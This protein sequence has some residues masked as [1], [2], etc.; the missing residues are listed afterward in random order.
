ML[1]KLNMTFPAGASETEQI[2][3]R[4]IHIVAGITWVGLLYFFNLVSM[5]VMKQLDPSTR[6]KVMPPLMLKALWYFRWAAVVT[7]LAGFRYFMILA[8]TDADAAGNPSLMGD[9]S[10]SGS[11]AGSLPSQS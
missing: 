5:P 10:E 8:Q 1:Y 7:W 9:G 2:V 6:G 11:S 3:L 4:W